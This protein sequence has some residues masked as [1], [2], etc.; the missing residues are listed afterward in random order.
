MGNPKLGL[1]TV[2]YD[3]DNVLQ[4]FFE[5][6][7]IQTYKDFHLYLI[8]NTP[9][10]K[11]DAL[12]L[13]LMT[14]Y[15][16]SNIT[17][18]RNEE[19][20]GVAKGNNQ[21]IALSRA[22]GTTHTLLLNNDIEFSQVD[23]LQGLMGRSI[24][25]GE[26]LI[27]PKI[28]FFES[29]LIWTAGGKQQKLRG[30]TKHIGEGKADADKYNIEK[31]VDYAP[32]CFMLINNS[33]FDRVGVMDEKY[34]VYYDDTDFIFRAVT[35]GYTI[36]YYPKYVVL[37]KVGSLTGGDESLFNIYWGTRNRIYFIRKNY[38]FFWQLG[39]ISFT[40]FWKFLKCVGYTA[41][42]R[43]KMMQGIVDGLKLQF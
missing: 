29:K 14:K 33:V 1:V 32:T 17:H 34:F 22:A 21:G 3:S 10:D 27:V 28:L 25:Q 8:D 35:L 6:I 20:V 24:D 4:G 37:H 16:I 18:V 5:S 7:S 40:L 26:P 39:A 2:L 12:I 42:Q 23:L 36:L 9:N 13:A 38:S 43:S 11:S 15:G 30:T 31:Y 19:N 41:S